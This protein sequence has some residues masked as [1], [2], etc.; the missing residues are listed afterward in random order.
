M[1]PPCT[2]PFGLRCLPS[3][4]IL[5]TARLSSASNSSAPTSSLRPPFS[6]MPI[7]FPGEDRRKPAF[8]ALRVAKRRLLGRAPAMRSGARILCQRP[9]VSEAV[10]QE[11]AALRLPGLLARPAGAVQQWR[12][13][14]RCRRCRQMDE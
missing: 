1:A 6:S 14:R 3:A 5:T 11:R 8:R 4:R 7:C 2:V 12:V 13:A 10:K 9:R